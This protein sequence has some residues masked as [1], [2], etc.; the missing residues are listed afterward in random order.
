MK[1][2]LFPTDFSQTADNAFV[3]AL[4]LAKSLGADLHV[5][6]TYSMP[7]VS[8]LGVESSE[9]VQQVYENVELTSFEKLK[10]QASVLRNVAEQENASEVK[11]SFLFQEGDLIMNILE[12][13][14]K[15]NIDLVVMGTTGA[16][17][18]EQKF[19]GSNTI[20]AIK[21]VDI[22]ILAVPHLAKFNGITKIGFTTI[23]KDSDKQ[24]L[25]EVLK[26]AEDFDAKVRCFHVAKDTQDVTIELAVRDWKRDFASDK[27]KFIINPLDEQTVEEH[28][29]DFV[30]D[31]NISILAIVKRNQTFF[32]R[33][34]GSSLSK[35]LASKPEVPLL[36][37]KEAKNQ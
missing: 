19:F 17:G 32:E 2:I 11:L 12:A 13:I 33:L 21:A 18:F 29:S 31:F 24:P 36:I 14:S 1:N 37:I 8:G 23:F 20:N 30:K 22:P 10:E 5:L 25:A 4:H 7:I 15:E 16:S 26:L 6:H 27:L 28:I 34:F 35:K 9:V 3:Y